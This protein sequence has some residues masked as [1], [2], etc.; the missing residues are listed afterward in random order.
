MKE[1]DKITCINPTVR[2]E[3]KASGESGITFKTFPK[4]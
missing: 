2:R 1:N 3:N 4:A